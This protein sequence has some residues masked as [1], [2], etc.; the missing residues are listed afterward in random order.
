MKKILA[1]VHRDFKSGIRD[2][3]IVYLCLAP[4]LIAFV[5]RL[6][7]PAAHS[8]SFISLGTLT[9][10]PAFELLSP[11]TRVEVFNSQEALIKR[12]EKNDDLIGII[13]KQDKTY[14]FI[15]QGN[16]TLD[17]EPIVK[18]LL[19]QELNPNTKPLISVKISDIGYEMSP[20]K[21]QGGILLMLFTTV[22]GGMFI[23]LN[24][25][26]EKMGQTLKA[27]NVTPISRLQMIIGKSVIGF[28]LPIIG[29]FG[30]AWILGFKGIS[31]GLFLLTILSTALISMIIGFVIG[32]LNN[33]P[34][35][36]V[37][38]MK[39]VFLPVLVS[40]FGAMFLNEKW[41]P[42]LYWSPFYWAYDSLHAILTNQAQFALVGKNALIILVLTGFVFLALKKKIN[43]GFN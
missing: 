13:S 38:S 22:F 36:A 34:I 16:E 37:A 25:V 18:A 27:L 32:I 42:I 1:I 15:K 24:F 30:A 4:F 40:V 39:I 17:A 19:Y 20:L 3:L 7:I 2:W 8:G 26:D 6:F 23:V 9:N 14:T 35:A 12:I 29:S 21:L 28:S 11:Y 33:E 41:H 10:D 43:E 5:L 31:Y